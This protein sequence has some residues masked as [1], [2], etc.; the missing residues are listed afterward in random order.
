MVEGDG[1][2]SVEVVQIVFVGVIISMPCDYIK[3]AVV[4]FVDKCFALEA[5]KKAPHQ[6]WVNDVVIFN[7]GCLWC[8]EV[9]FVGETVR[10]DWT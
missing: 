4:L 6:I 2:H 5:C 8:K 1:P 7:I 9:S 10:T 3:G